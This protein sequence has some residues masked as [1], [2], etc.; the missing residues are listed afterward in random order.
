M[1]GIHAR[2]ITDATG[3]LLIETKPYTSPR[4]HHGAWIGMSILAVVLLILCALLAG[5]TLGVC[6]LDST[7]LQ[8][9]CITGTPRERYEATL[10]ARIDH[11]DSLAGDKHEW[12]LA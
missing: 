3:S 2:N 5:L 9:R 11:A 12:S 4:F 10:G 1:V 8:M 7:L 6:G